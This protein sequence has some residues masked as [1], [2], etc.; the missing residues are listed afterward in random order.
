MPEVVVPGDDDPPLLSST[1]GDQLVSVGARNVGDE[2]GIVAGFSEPVEQ[3]SRHAFI[4]Q[5][6]HLRR[7]AGSLSHLV[8]RPCE[9]RTN[10]V[11]RD[12]GIGGD[13]LFHRSAE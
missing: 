4:D 2:D 13:D 7:F 8:R 1:L 12:R 5:K 11:G 6:A 9:S 10:I 3:L